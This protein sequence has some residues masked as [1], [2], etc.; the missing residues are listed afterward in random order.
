MPGI[1]RITHKPLPLWWMILARTTGGK[2]G[3]V[4]GLPHC[5]AHHAL[6][7]LWL[8]VSIVVAHP[9][10]SLSVFTVHCHC[11]YSLSPSLF[12]LTSD[13]LALLVSHCVL[14]SQLCVAG[15]GAS[16]KGP[17]SRCSRPAAKPALIAGTPISRNVIT[18][19]QSNR[20]ALIPIL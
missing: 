15:L 18:L 4:L 2:N 12:T 8:T 19:C 17:I 10:Y 1:D 13:A 14:F 7:W 20:M 9:Q 5:H 11:Q 16:T 3:L 6:P